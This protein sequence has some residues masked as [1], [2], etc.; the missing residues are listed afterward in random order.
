MRNKDKDVKWIPTK[1]SRRKKLLIKEHVMDMIQV[2]THPCYD[3]FKNTHSDHFKENKIHVIE[4]SSEAR[5]YIVC[6][7][8]M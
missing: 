2:Q 4:T 7:A 1:S 3:T 6:W 8:E 5:L